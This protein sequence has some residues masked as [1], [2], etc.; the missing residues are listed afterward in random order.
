ME[1]RKRERA[2]NGFF[3]LEV[4]ILALVCAI[5]S[6]FLVTGVQVC[7]RYIACLQLRT[8]AGIFAQDLLRTRE[9]ALA[10]SNLAYVEVDYR[11][12]GYWVYRK[13]NLGLKRDFAS[14]RPA[15]FRFTTMPVQQIHFS[16]NG[17]PSACG[18]FVLQHLRCPALKMKIILQPVTGRVRVEQCE[19]G[20]GW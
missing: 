19:D 17:V 15:L 20:S 14:D 11:G 10:G 4:V 6:G 1:V 9:R 8:A 13:P 7:Q 5:F 16:I 12:N 18:T 2:V 3:L